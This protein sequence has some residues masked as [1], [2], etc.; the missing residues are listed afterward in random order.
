MTRLSVLLL[1]LAVALPVCAQAPAAPAAASPE[2][3][4]SER[5]AQYLV[6]SIVARHPE[7]GEVD[8]HATPPASTRSMIVAAKTASHVGKASDPDD[9]AVT[10]SGEARVEINARGNQ[11][12]EVELPLVDIY[13]QTIG[14]VELTFPYTPGADPQAMIAVATQ[15]RDQI[16]RRILDQAS[17]FEPVQLDPRV[18]VHRYSQFLVDDTLAKYPEIEVVALHARTPQT[19]GDYLIIASNIRSRRS[20]VRGSR[21]RRPWT[22]PIRQLGRRSWRRKRSSNTT[23]RSSATSKNCR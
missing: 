13:N 5:Y 3:S 20:C 23:S 12:V 18:P 11:N 2:P 6:D 16:S 9:I 21:A 17:L 15:Y 22:N 1:A 4:P 19:G 14:A 10:K 7:L 8:V